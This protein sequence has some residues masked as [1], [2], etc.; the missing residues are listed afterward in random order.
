MLRDVLTLPKNASAISFYVVGDQIHKRGLSCAVCSDDAVNPGSFF[1][2][3]KIR[4][5]WYNKQN[6]FAYYHLCIG[7]SKAGFIMGEYL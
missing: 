1:I 7:S 3:D 4:M 2:L 6:N 5:I